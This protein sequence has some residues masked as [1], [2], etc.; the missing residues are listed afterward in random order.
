MRCTSGSLGSNAGGDMGW[1][2]VSC[3]GFDALGSSLALMALTM[4]RA[5][6]F[7]NFV[8]DVISGSLFFHIDII[9]RKVE[10]ARSVS[11]VCL[12]RLVS[13]PVATASYM[14]A[15]PLTLFSA[16]SLSALASVCRANC[17]QYALATVSSS[18]ASSLGFSAFACSSFSMRSVV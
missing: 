6:Y 16:I 2:C 10:A 8:L 9:S 17:S 1:S 15:Y 13:R 4:R 18:K 12:F 14:C 5:W 11:A 3:T 7:A